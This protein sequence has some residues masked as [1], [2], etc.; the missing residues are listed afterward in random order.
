MGRMPSHNSL[1][2]CK[3]EPDL[4]VDPRKVSKTTTQGL[5]VCFPYKHYSVNLFFVDQHHCGLNHQRGQ[6]ILRKWSNDS[7]QTYILNLV[8]L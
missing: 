8:V 5:S 4:R 2:S 7:K 3:V 1:V 6:F